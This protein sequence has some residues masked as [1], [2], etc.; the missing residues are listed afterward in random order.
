LQKKNLKNLSEAIRFML[1]STLAFALMNTFIKELNQYSPFQLVF[2]RSFGSL[3]FTTI[4][5][6]VNKISFRGNKM[7]LLLYRGLTGVISMFRICSIYFCW[8]CCYAPICSP[9]FCCN[10]GCYFSK[11]K[12][13]SLAMVFL[14]YRFYWG[15]FN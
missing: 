7:S 9:T 14:Y 5:L 11:R 2:F 3:F 10:L 1:L 15:C 6:K 8:V 4:Y 12:Y 13:P